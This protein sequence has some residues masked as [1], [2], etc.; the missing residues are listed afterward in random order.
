MRQIVDLEM[1]FSPP[2][3]SKAILFIILSLCAFFAATAVNKPRSIKESRVGDLEMIQLLTQYLADPTFRTRTGLSLLAYRQ[4]LFRGLYYLRKSAPSH[5][6]LKTIPE[7]L[8]AQLPRRWWIVCWLLH[9]MTQP[10]EN[11]DRSI[12]EHRLRKTARAATEQLAF[13]R[14]LRSTQ[15]TPRI[16]VIRRRYL[17]DVV[18]LGSVFRSLRRHF[19]TST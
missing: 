8:Q 3:V 19:H 7:L 4:V 17:G 14:T 13:L 18:L 6:Q 1:W 2:L 5:P 16:L 11:L 9:R 15:A 10:F 12:R